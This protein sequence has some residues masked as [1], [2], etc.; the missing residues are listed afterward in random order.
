MGSL[1][2][3]ENKIRKAVNATEGMTGKVVFT[4]GCFDLVHTG[5]LTYLASARDLGDHLIIGVNSD[6]SV[7]KLK[8]PSRPI[9]DEV[10]RLLL[11]ASLEFVDAVVLFGEDTPLE[12]IRTIQP[13]VLVKGR[14][15]D[16]TST[17]LQDPKY[18]VGS[19]IVMANGGTVQTIPFVE[20]YSTTRLVDKM[21]Q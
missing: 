3:I 18:V 15:Y 2:N 5:H 11:L 21:N 1:N 17:D 13:D 4:N 9:K 10:N 12:L 7:Q 6:A 20:G 16:P 14:D 8:G 19:D